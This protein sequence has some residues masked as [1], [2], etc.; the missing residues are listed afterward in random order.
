MQH[1]RC[2]AEVKASA[3]ASCWFLG[4]EQAAGPPHPFGAWWTLEIIDI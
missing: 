4:E 3:R 1:G 2:G